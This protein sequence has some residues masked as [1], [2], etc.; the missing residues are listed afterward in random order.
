MR[1]YKQ[2]LDVIPKQMLRLNTFKQKNIKITDLSVQNDSPYIWF[3]ADSKEMI[4]VWFYSFFTG[5]AIPDYITEK[6]YLG[7]YSL[8]NGTVVHVF[9]KL[10]E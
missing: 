1:I 4:Q 5:E 9:M 8:S 2:K 3:L 10:E 7:K 6:D